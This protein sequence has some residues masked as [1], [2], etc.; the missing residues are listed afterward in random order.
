M[1]EKKMFAKQYL[2]WA[3]KESNK[4]KEQNK[5]GVNIATQVSTMHGT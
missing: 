3:L 1:Q 2:N 5:A 4:E